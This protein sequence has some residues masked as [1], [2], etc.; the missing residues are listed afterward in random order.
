LEGDLVAEAF[1]LFDE[2]AP[3]AFG[4]LG[5]FAVEE[6]LAELVVTDALLEDV[7]GGGEIL[8]AVAMVALACP[9]RLSIR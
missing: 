1:E 3:V 9:R 2:S 7:V 4:G 6:V 8:W 5:V